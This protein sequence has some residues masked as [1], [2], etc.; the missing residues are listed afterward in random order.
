MKRIYF[1]LE[2]GLKSDKIPNTTMNHAPLNE[3]KYPLIPDELK[4]YANVIR[5]SIENG[6]CEIFQNS[7]HPH[8]AVIM[9][10]FC[11]AAQRTLYI[12]C[13]RLNHMVYE[14]LWP[15]FKSA[16]ERD[17][18]VRVLTETSNVE[19]IELAKELQKAGVLRCLGYNP[20]LPH[21]AIIDGKMSRLET[22][23]QQ[24]SAFV[25]TNVSSDDNVG[26]ERMELLQ[27]V[28]SK[29]WNSATP[30]KIS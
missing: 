28:F 19:S 18:D 17:V 23:R 8:A 26:Q 12:F 27:N 1:R 9:Q 29:L 13:G 20:E 16:L 25:R 24:C 6:D 7:S 10:L 22:S 4:D 14:R 5:E 2:L 11:E 15:V 21:F 3:T 30:I